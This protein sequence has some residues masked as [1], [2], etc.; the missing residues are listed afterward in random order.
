MYQ[1]AEQATS[2]VTRAAGSARPIAASCWGTDYTLR[3]ANGHVRLST[4]EGAATTAARAQHGWPLLQLPVLGPNALP[5]HIGATLLGSPTNVHLRFVATDAL[6]ALAE[7]TRAGGEMSRRRWRSREARLLGEALATADRHRDEFLAVLSHELRSPLAAIR[8]AAHLVCSP[9]TEAQARH[10]AQVLLERQLQRVMHLVDDLL[11]LSR[12]TLGRIPLNRERMDLRIAVNNAIETLETD[13]Q[14]RRHRLTVALPATAVWL[15]GDGRRL[16]QV[17]VNLLANACKFTDTGGELA[18]HLHSSGGQAMVQ[19]RDSGI[20]ID[21]HSLPYIFDPFKQLDEGAP[22]PEA[23]LGIGLALVRQYVK[24]H[25]G[26]VT[27]R[28]AGRGRG[29]EFAVQ[30][31]TEG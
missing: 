28:S 22:H 23:G 11:D 17:F 18:V 2:Q 19:F 7:A 29:S 6:L 25:G 12:L 1:E 20:G 24:L 9:A 31:P 16:E 21:S 10:R 15:H 26:S 4:Q 27:V 3:L 5:V 13:I 30:L 8:N 14:Q